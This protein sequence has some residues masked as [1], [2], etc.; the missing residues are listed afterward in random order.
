MEF[1]T[2]LD[3]VEMKIKIEEFKNERSEKVVNLI[4]EDLDSATVDLS[5]SSVDEVKELFDSIYEYIISN[6][7]LIV[8]DLINTDNNLFVEV[9]KD[10]VEHLN[11][12]IEQ[13]EE[14]FLQ[15]IRIQKD[16]VIEA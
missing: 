9:A 1:N 14:N 15:L 16:T 2:E 12:E 6:E 4:V 8:F 5:N 7:K 10:L 11:H 13:S 3:K